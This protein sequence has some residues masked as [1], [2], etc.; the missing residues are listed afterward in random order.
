MQH[1][2]PLYPFKIIAGTLIIVVMMLPQAACSASPSSSPTDGPVIQTESLVVES[3]ASQGQTD[4]AS[5][6]PAKTT[7]ENATVQSQPEETSAAASPSETSGAFVA[8]TVTNW[9]LTE[10]GQI[11]WY[12][13]APSMIPYNAAKTVTVTIPEGYTLVD[14]CK[15][16]EKKGV[17]TFYHTFSAA[18]NGD[19]PDYAFTDASKNAPNRRYALEGYLFPDTYQFHVGEKPVNIWAKFLSKMNS[20]LSSYSAYPG[21]TMDQILTLASLIE[22]EA[23]TGDTRANVSSVLHNRLKAGQR[24]ELDKTINYVEW[25]IKP[26]IQSNDTGVINAYNSYYNTYKCPALP[27]GPITNPG[28]LAIEAALNPAQTAYYY[29]VTDPAGNYYY[30]STWEEHQANLVTAGLA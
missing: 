24:L 10:S 20:V 23:F 2:R 9:T 27:A 7:S 26:L 19:Y 22:E 21:M 5:E 8:N 1:K 14:I 11:L 17:Q 29:F 25:Y 18:L 16:L 6:A 15:L 30:A 12:D 3:S 28:R 13:P 4:Q